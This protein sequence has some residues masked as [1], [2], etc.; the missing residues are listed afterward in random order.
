MVG[1]CVIGYKNQG[2][3]T[4]QGGDSHWGAG[5]VSVFLYVQEMSL[6]FMYFDV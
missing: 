2:F 6:Y 3:R 4:K 5:N 1:I